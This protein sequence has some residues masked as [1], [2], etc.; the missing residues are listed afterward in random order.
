LERIIAPT[1]VDG[2]G[3]WA[4]VALL[5]VRDERG[6]LGATEGQETM[7]LKKANIEEI[8]DAVEEEE[9]PKFELAPPAKAPSD[10]PATWVDILSHQEPTKVV[11]DVLCSRWPRACPGR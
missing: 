4:R 8:L 9:S 6:L 7:P 1:R 10:L 11:W 3:A 2:E 5:E